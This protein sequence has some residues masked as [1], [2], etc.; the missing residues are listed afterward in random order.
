M[1]FRLTRKKRAGDIEFLMEEWAV[2]EAK[3]NGELRVH[4]ASSNAFANQKSLELAQ[5]GGLAPGSVSLVIQ[6]PD[7]PLNERLIALPE[8]SLRKGRTPAESP[9]GTYV[10]RAEFGHD[11]VLDSFEAIHPAGVEIPEFESWAAEVLD[12]E[13]HTDDSHRTVVFLI[14]QLTRNGAVEIRGSH[15]LLPQCCCI[16]LEEY[17]PV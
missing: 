12:L 4:A 13:F 11:R 7:H 10:F 6:E 5:G 16:W 17:C 15:V 9:F 14:L 3:G 8:P 2:V 1:S